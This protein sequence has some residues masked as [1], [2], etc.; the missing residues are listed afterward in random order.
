M[1]SSSSLFAALAPLALVAVPSEAAVNLTTSVDYL[2]SR[3]QEADVSAGKA[4]SGQSEERYTIDSHRFR[5]N[6]PATDRDSVDVNLIY[7]SMSGASPWFVMPDAQGKPVQVMSGAS[8][9]EDRIAIQ[10]SWNHEWS[11]LV[12]FKL[13][14]GYSDENDYRSL[15]AGLEAAWTADDQMQILSVG[16]G[17]SADTLT[18]TDGGSVAYPTRITEASRDGVTAFVSLEQ[19]LSPRTRL[20]FAISSLWQDGFLSDPY[21]L[22]F[23]TTTANTVADSRPDKRVGG[24]L[25]LMLRHSLAKGL[26]AHVDYRYYQDDW[27]VQA[28]SL[29][30]GLVRSRGNWQWAANARWY[31]QSQAGFY[32]PFYT[33]VRSDGLAS[34]DYRLSPFGALGFGFDVKRLIGPWT[35]GAGAGWY[36]ASESFALGN[37]EVANPGL[38]S[39]LNGHVRVTRSY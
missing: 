26:A 39:W 11:R 4:A 35:L 1:K 36:K 30:M 32:A 9:S 29:A 31:S 17:Y 6:L 12:S 7:E 5:I 13:S 22:A 15:Q 37:V 33:M 21:K 14:G 2:Y 3:Y 38:V 16:L 18:P 28:H 8:I 27:E 10:G 24:A 34:S 20:Q 25:S 23:I 19:V